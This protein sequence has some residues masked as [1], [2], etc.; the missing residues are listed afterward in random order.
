[1]MSWMNLAA[2]FDLRLTMGRTLTHLVNLSMVN[3][4]WLNPLGAFLNSLTM[5]WH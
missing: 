1:M 4:R 5:S 3:R 2:H